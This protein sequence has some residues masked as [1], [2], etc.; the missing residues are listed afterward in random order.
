VNGFEWGRKWP[1]KR[2]QG[3]EYDFSHLDPFVFEAI[4]G[5]PS[6]PRIKVGVSF[7]LHTFT[8]ERVE[9]DAPD[10]LMV[11]DNDRRT[12]CPHRHKCSLHLPA[13]VRGVADKDVNISQGNYMIVSQVDCADGEYATVFQLGKSD[14]KFI[15]VRMRVIS[16]H[17]RLRGLGLMRTKSFYSLVRKIAFG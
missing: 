17:E 1:K 9:G 15:L 10:T 6:A 16:A 2:F 8:K 13:I 5:D 3:H 7:S 14:G 12:F 4:P 11:R